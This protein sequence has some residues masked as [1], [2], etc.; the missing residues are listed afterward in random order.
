[1]SSVASIHEI[2]TMVKHCC[3]TIRT[4]KQLTLKPD[5]TNEDITWFTQSK[6]ELG[7]M[8][9]KMKQ[10]S[11]HLVDKIRKRQNKRQRQ[12]QRREERRKIKKQRE[13]EMDDWMREKRREDVMKRKSF[14]NRRLVSDKVTEIDKHLS[15]LSHLEKLSSTLGGNIEP[16]TP[17][18]STRLS[19]LRKRLER[20][21]ETEG[22]NSEYLFGA[23]D[24]SI[25]ETL[26]R[27][28]LL[29]IR[30][31]WDQFISS[32]ATATS[33]PI[34]WVTLSSE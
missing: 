25:E 4:M 21:G 5:L 10:L 30:H 20:D 29:E 11:P 12:K 28:Q 16:A 27:D 17:E 2:S 1:M 9:S 14:Q 6:I 32:E 8:L 3:Q 18:L 15:L 34:G 24:S 26:T 23:E 22:C 13:E 19:E 31:D 7:A 33:I